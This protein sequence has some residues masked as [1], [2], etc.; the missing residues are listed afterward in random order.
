[1]HNFELQQKLG[2][3]FLVRTRCFLT[4]D[5]IFSSDEKSWRKMQQWINEAALAICCFESL[6]H[7]TNI[8]TAKKPS[9]MTKKIS[10]V[11]R[12]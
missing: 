6:T 8:G 12:R 4:Q 2:F 5:L 7:Y 9:I 11:L 10:T 3:K 1:M